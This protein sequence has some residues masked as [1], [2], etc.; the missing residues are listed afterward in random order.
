MVNHI[1][2]QIL[3]VS[4]SCGGERNSRSQGVSSKALHALG[5]LAHREWLIDDKEPPGLPS[6]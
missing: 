5:I 4:N 6:Q 2:L 1:C 3:C